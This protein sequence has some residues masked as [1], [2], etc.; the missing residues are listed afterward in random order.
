MRPLRIFVVDDDSDFALA[1]ANFLHL[2]GHQVEMASTGEE[3]V[4]KL[5]KEDFDVTLMDVKLPGMN[6][7]QS[8]LE[9]KKLKPHAKVFMMTAYSLED[10]LRQ[11]IDEGVLGVLHKP[12]DM[13]EVMRGLE[14]VGEAGIVL[15]ADDDP[16]FAKAIEWQ[17]AEA[18]YVVCRA[19]TGAEA[20][21]QVLTGRIDYLVLDL[22]LPA[23]SGLEV[24]RELE[25]LGRTV[26]TII[27]TGYALEETDAIDELK[28]LSVAGC[29]VKPFQSAEL[30]RSLRELAEGS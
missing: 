30:L 16:D 5:G 9:I 23:L 1:T 2:E 28:T 26:P 21:E 7:V 14:A 4:A 27:V 6:G 22:R 12:L 15:L 29:L 19:A 17:L 24:Y 20:L 10:L 25:R 13:G 18:G 3:A 8:F 11:A